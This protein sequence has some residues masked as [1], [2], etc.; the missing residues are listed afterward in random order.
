MLTCKDTG[1]MFANHMSKAWHPDP[2]L[3]VFIP[4]KFTYKREDND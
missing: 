2:T 4:F 3:I 1:S